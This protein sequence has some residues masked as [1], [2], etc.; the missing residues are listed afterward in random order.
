MSADGLMPGAID[1]E[2][3]P[4]WRHPAFGWT[5]A[6][7][8]TVALCAPLWQPSLELALLGIESAL[9]EVFTASHIGRI[10][11]VLIP[12]AA[13]GF[14]VLASVSPC[15]LPLVP[16]NLAY[17]GAS[18]ASGRRA[19]SL[20]FRFVVGSALALTVLG[21]FGDLAGLL[22]IDH[23]GP[24]L[25]TAGI[26]IVYLGLAALE[27]APVPGPGSVFSAQRRLGPVGAGAA[28]S[29][30]TTPCSSPLLAAVLTAAAAQSVS[31]LGIVTM[32]SFSLGYTM[33]VFLAGVF[34]G[35]VV[36]W[37][38]GL[39]MVAPRAAAAALLV[40]SGTTFV[41]SGAVWLGL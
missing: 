34:G 9:A 24:V 30:I 35:G 26:A 29:L 36:A 12:A 6:L 21:V 38:R 11:L 23:R 33:L 1:P 7:A 28:F 2:R 20:S 17:I 18:E 31:G 27:L 5:L 19:L 22:L 3:G 32:L 15:V 4:L 25:L 39:D 8:T 16:V 14:G 41:L 10:G 13:F 40:V 37:A